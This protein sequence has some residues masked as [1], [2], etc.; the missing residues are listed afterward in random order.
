[1]TFTE[2]VT[3]IVEQLNLTSAEATARVGRKVNR[4]YRKITASI[5]LNVARRTTVQASVTL[6]VQ[7]LTFTGIEKITA[8]SDR[9]TGVDRFL[10]PVSVE[11]LKLGTI[12]TSPIVYYAINRMN[13]GSVEILMDI[14]PQE[15]LTLYADGY[16]T[17]STLSGAQEPAFPES[18]H[19]ILIELV[20]ASEYKKKGELVAAKE[21]KDAAEELLADLRYFIAKE[22]FQ[23][24]YQGKLSHSTLLSGE[25][26]G[27]GG[28][29]SAPDGAQSYTQ[30]GLITFDRD[31]LAPFA[32]TAS[33]AVVTNLDADMLDG[34]HETAFAKLADNET[35][36][37][38]WEF[39]GTVTVNDAVTVNDDI[40]VTG[41]T[42][43]GA[44]STLSWLGRSIITSPADGDI[45]LTDNAGTD[46]D[47]L[48]FGGGTSSFPALRRTNN[49]LEVV[50]ADES[51]YTDLA[52]N[53]LNLQGGRITFPATQVPS[54]NANTLDD[55]EEGTF[56]PT[57]SSDG[58]GSASYTTN[59]GRY[60]KIGRYVWIGGN[61][62]LSSKGTLA[63]GSVAVA[64]LPFTVVTS[65]AFDIGVVYVAYFA[66]LATAV[67]S[68][69]GHVNPNNTS[70]TLY[71][72]PA[73]GATGTS[74]LQ[75]SDLNNT[76][77][78]IFSAAYIAAA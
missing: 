70:I 46:F 30:T 52:V 66:A 23:D 6:G 74:P 21:S 16:E 61:I 47:V 41:S 38:N 54:A 11:E 33:S 57:L 20:C 7:T 51:Q 58:G 50:L 53:L 27:S 10:T 18:F 19:D 56:T 24:S 5:G 63:A 64:G 67:S 49:A 43:L 62:T 12:G 4:E 13:A 2:I 78:F 17:A 65:S 25:V 14:V 1:M 31:P 39:D 75:V 69:G 15:A 26:S 35:I 36:T 60:I 55:Y 8:V 42:T 28:S 9:S 73:A 71:F 40:T 77:S 32:V 37:G 68:L 48:Q 76:S 45:R 34:F 59:N 44:S 22:A 29:S 72:V 3:E